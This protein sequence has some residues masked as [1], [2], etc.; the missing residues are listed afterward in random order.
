MIWNTSEPFKAPDIDKC[1]WLFTTD[2]FLAPPFFAALQHA[3]LNHGSDRLPR[4]DRRN[5]YEIDFIRPFPC[6][7]AC[8]AQQ[9]LLHLR[10]FLFDQLAEH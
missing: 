9:P 6:V 3:F 2:S 7:A 5:D 4:K 10:H 8:I 1:F